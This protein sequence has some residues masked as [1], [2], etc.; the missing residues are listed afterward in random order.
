MVSAK[1]ILGFLLK[2]YNPLLKILVIAIN[3]AVEPVCKQASDAAQIMLFM[4]DNDVNYCNLLFYDVYSFLMV[5]TCSIYI[6][7]YLHVICMYLYINL[8]IRTHTSRGTRPGG[9][10]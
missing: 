5:S 10:S 6:Y 8:Y 4:I 9:G 3:K 2:R 7:I 1:L